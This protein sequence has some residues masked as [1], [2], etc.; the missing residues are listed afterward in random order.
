MSTS[1]AANSISWWTAS[2][3]AT[4]R[5]EARPSP[6]PCSVLSDANT[7]AVNSTLSIDIS[8]PWNSKDVKIRSIPKPGPAKA[9]VVLWTDQEAGV[10]YSWG[11]KFP[12]GRDIKDPE[13]W[14]FTADGEGGGT[15]SAEDPANP[16]RFG[17]LHPTEDGAY[18]NTPSQGFVI[19]G[20]ADAYTEPGFRGAIPIPGMVSFDMKTKLWQ[21]GTTNFSPF[22]TTTLIQASAEYIPTFGPEGLIMVLGGYAPTNVNEAWGPAFDLG[23]L[24]FFNPE[25]KKSYWQTATGNIPPTPRGQACSTVFHTPDGG[26]DM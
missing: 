9:G 17:D 25:T 18:A 21:N 10:L 11:G 12:G 20:V 19:G 24:T 2:C 4:F 8:K 16:T 14:K 6:R 23:N 26:S 5:R 13:L 15:W 3:G 22:G 1:T 7:G